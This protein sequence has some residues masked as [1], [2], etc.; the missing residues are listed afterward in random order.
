MKVQLEVW[1]VDEFSRKGDTAQEG[2]RVRV[3]PMG[4]PPGGMGVREEPEG[5]VE[6]GATAVG[7]EGGA[8]A[9]PT[10]MPDEV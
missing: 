4:T 10:E 6:D 5:Q 1:G 2:K 3:R 9:G 8:R 7:G